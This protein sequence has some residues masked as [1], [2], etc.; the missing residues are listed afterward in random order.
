M[1]LIDCGNRPRLRNLSFHRKVM[2]DAGLHCS[3]SWADKR[4]SGLVIWTSWNSTWN[5]GLLNSNSVLSLPR[6]SVT[7]TTALVLVLQ[8]ASSFTHSKLPSLSSSPWF[9][10]LKFSFLLPYQSDRRVHQRLSGPPLPNPVLESVQTEC[11]RCLH[12]VS[13]PSC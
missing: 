1:P 2:D 5:F 8:G 12:V 10:K 13:P 6:L 7:I 3:Y 9:G 11:A 4:Q